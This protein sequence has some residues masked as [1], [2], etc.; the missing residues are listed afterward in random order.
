LECDPAVLSGH[1]FGIGVTKTP[2]EL[3]RA[4]LP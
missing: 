2:A 1:S 3:N 4:D